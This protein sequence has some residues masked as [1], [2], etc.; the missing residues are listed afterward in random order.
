MKRNLELKVAYW[1]YTLGLTQD[2]IARRISTTR[3]K[4]NQI[5]QSLKPLGIVSVSIHG[6]ERDHIELETR[7]EEAFGLNEVL[8]V[9]DYG[10][11]E[12]AVFR[13]ASV[14]AQYLDEVISQ[15]M[16]IGVSWGRTI[17]A[18]IN[19]MPYHPRTSCRVL[20]LLGARNISHSTEKADEISR[21]LANRL[22]C[23]CHILYAP[24]VVD[25]PQT[26][27]WLMRED[28]ILQAFELMPQC[29]IA[30]VGIGELDETSTLATRGLVSIADIQQMRRAGFVADLSLNAVRLDG[31]T[32]GNPFASRVM[33]ADLDC[34]RRIRNTVA[35]ASGEGKKEA[36]AAAFRTGAINTA[37]LDESLARRLVEDLD[38][39]GS[40]ARQDRGGAAS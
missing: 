30:L 7:I 33:A 40:K 32:D 13:V 18:T 26:K 28:S 31:S 36:V 15:G 12:T 2:E 3:Q 37:I 35:I 8:V 4:V 9:T 21:N 16:L 38:A 22:N 29:D 19:D 1:Y 20:Q 14:A 5:I 17:A 23:P 27:E 11:K 39:Q 6:F 10:E 34:L 25:N 24:V